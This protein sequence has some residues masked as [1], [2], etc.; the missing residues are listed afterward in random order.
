[1]Y[2]RS[3]ATEGEVS[4]TD[5][6]KSYYNEKWL[7]RLRGLRMLCGQQKIVSLPTPVADGKTLHIVFY[8]YIYH[9]I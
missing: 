5:E 8:F 9:Y 3:Y 7:W 1:M 2:E 6:E 4:C